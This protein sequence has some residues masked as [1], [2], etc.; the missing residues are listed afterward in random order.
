MNL[1]G[2]E[3]LETSTEKLLGQTFF[4]ELSR[5]R[6]LRDIINRYCSLANYSN[7]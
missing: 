3:I 5:A 6:E 1:R 4:K 7:K 2:V